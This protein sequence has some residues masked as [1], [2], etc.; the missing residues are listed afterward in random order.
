MKVLFTGASSFTGFWFARQ[1]LKQGH[2]VISVFRRDRAG[3]VEAPRR[4][5]VEL[6]AP[7]CRSIWGVSF[8]EPAF[9]DVIAAERDWDLLCH[10]AADV[11]N[12]RSADFDVARALGANTRNAP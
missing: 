9:L 1:L 2:D 6:L 8:G 12:Y 11:A 4:E 3:Y 5:R 10:H 7:L